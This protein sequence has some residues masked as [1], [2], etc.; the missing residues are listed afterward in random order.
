[1]IPP[2][3]KRSGGPAYFQKG[4]L[5]KLRYDFAWRATKIES[6]IDHPMIVLEVHGNAIKVLR[7]DG[8]IKSD[9]SENYILLP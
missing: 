5:V 8:T 7:P 2:K 3:L 6:Y 9:L 4:D 1:M